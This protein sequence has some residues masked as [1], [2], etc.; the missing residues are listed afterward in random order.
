MSFK[1]GITA[2]EAYDRILR[3]FRKAK[4]LAQTRRA[5]FIAGPVNA[6]VV[7]RL[8]D[9][10]RTHQTNIGLYVG[11]P[12]LSEYAKDQSGDTN[13]DIL[14]EGQAA[15]NAIAA[16]PNWLHTNMPRTPSGE[17]DLNVWVGET[18][19][20]RSFTV[21]QTAGLIPLLDAVDSLIEV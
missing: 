7:L 1:A 8:M 13:Y 11:V 16:I 20:Y 10:F 14:A 21:A 15:R 17:P 2:A 12:G 3:E 18:V 19:G 6:I 9:G 4:Q 5:E